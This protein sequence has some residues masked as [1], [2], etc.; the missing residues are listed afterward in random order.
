MDLSYLEIDLEKLILDQFVIHREEDRFDFRFTTITVAAFGK[1]VSRR[2][3]KKDLID[4]DPGKVYSY[5]QA[6]MKSILTE[7]FERINHG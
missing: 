5:Q 4:I 2:V 7:L 1:S 6:I 3:L